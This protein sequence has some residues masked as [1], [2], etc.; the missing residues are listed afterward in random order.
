MGSR[1][2]FHTV[3]TGITG[4]VYF[5]PPSNYAITYPC[6]IYSRENIDTAHADNNPYK[7]EKQ[8]QVTVIDED[9]DSVLPDTIS[10]LPRSRFDRA[11]TSDGLHHTVF[12]IYF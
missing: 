7:L 6:I 4:N 2:D 1:L 5:Q 9:P 3:L 12:T 8:Y 11:Y 10:N